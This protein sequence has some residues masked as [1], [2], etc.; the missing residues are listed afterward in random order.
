[1][2]CCNDWFFKKDPQ[3]AAAALLKRERKRISDEIEMG[4]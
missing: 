2:L 1:M 4:N 3:E